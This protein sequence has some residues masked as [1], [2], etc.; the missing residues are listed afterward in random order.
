MLRSVLPLRAQL[1]AIEFFLELMER[2]VADL[3]E[4]AHSQYRPP[5]RR[6]SAAPQRIGGATNAA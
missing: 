2:I 6:N 1:G 3:L 4:A 5:R